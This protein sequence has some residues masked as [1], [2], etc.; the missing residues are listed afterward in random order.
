MQ[1]ITHLD[2]GGAERVA[3][4]LMKGLLGSC[5]FDLFA[6]LGVQPGEVGAGLYAEAQAMGLR[7]RQGTRVPV[8]YGGMLLAGRQLTRAVEAVRP[9]VIHL[10]TEYPRECLRCRSNAAI[11]GWRSSIGAHDS[12]HRLLDTL[13]APGPLV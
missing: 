5:D 10:H 4:T 9:D 1:V 6:V 11:E 12:Q 8:K 13:A 7:L 3:F 2:L